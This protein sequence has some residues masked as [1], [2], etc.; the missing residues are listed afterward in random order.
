MTVARTPID[1]R[2]NPDARLQVSRIAAELFWRDGVAGTRGEDIAAEAGIATRTLWRYFRSKE[3]CVEPVLVE[4]GRRFMTVL[5]AWPL[6]MSIDE[7][8]AAA[9]IDGEVEYTP[10]EVAAMRMVTLGFREPVL[11]SAWLMVC[12]ESE[13]QAA[14]LFAL[15]LGLK[16]R[17]LDVTQIAA[18]VSAA[19]RALTDAL[20]VEYI[21]RGVRMTADDVLAS[22][23][24]AVI[25]A[26]N[27]RLGPAVR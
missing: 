16:A 4:S 24:A 21:E 6:E 18:S 10:D 17:S 27:G 20:S 14:E 26:S 5:N 23:S 25:Q 1:L 15:R 12:D 19:I 8:F 2:R 9:R 22:L 11:R 3:S 13:R 7:Y